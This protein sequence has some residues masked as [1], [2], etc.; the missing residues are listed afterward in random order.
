VDSRTRGMVGVERGHSRCPEIVIS[1]IC[2]CLRQ[3]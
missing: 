2:R 1:G 3:L